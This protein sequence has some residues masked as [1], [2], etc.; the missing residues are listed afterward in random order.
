[1]SLSR[2]AFLCAPHYPGC[3]GGGG[4]RLTAGCTWF[5][6]SWIVFV[7]SLGEAGLQLLDHSVG[8]AVVDPDWAAA[9]G[10][11]RQ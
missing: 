4:G 3:G 7:D 6:Q 2:L 10:P 1:M 11:E 9:L 8:R 5:C